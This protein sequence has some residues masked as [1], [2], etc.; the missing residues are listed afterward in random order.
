[1]TEQGVRGRL[2]H[3]HWN[4]MHLKFPYHSVS[5]IYRGQDLG[6]HVIFT[7]DVRRMVTDEVKYF[8]SANDFSYSF[9]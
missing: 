9:I 1:M 8:L 7:E 2:N 5:V 6:L 4:L 3:I